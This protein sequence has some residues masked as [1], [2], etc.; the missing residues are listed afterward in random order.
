MRKEVMGKEISH[1]TKIERNVQ[2]LEI[3]IDKINT[4]S[5]TIPPKKFLLHFTKIYLKLIELV[6]QPKVKSSYL[7]RIDI[8]RLLRNFASLL[9]N[10][11]TLSE[12]Y[13][14]LSLFFQVHQMYLSLQSH[15]C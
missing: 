12:I 8:L 13:Q 3:A 11:G 2:F 10:G 14:F 1:T 5:K 6:H 7:V 4:K 15:R 9:R